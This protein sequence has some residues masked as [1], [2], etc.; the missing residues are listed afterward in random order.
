MIPPSALPAAAR[1]AQSGT[2]TAKRTAG[3]KADTLLD[4]LNKQQM[5]AATDASNHAIYVKAGPGTG[6]TRVIAA[7]VGAAR[8]PGF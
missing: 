2:P 6:K 1:K 7:R 5:D 4:S 8:Q 3:R